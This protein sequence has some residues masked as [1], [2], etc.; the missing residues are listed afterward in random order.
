MRASINGKIIGED[1]WEILRG[2]KKLSTSEM[3]TFE[4][5]L[6]IRELLSDYRPYLKYASGYDLIK[7][8]PKVLSKQWSRGVT[9]TSASYGSRFLETRV[10]EL[11][12][13]AKGDEGSAILLDCDG[14][15]WLETI[16]ISSQKKQSNY[17]IGHLTDTQLAGVMDWFATGSI[18]KQILRGL[19]LVLAK[20][21]DRARERAE[22]QEGIADHI[23]QI[24][25]R[26]GE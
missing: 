9:F 6:G 10:F 22:H 25:G 21:A 17:S 15:L 24:I 12:N 16:S 23:K 4:W 18:G 3:T 7:E 26:L 19:H 1:K 5:L 20:S 11:T 2:T 8:R 14:K 13:F